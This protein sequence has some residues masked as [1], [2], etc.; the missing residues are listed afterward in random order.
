[1]LPTSLLSLCTLSPLVFLDAKPDNP[2]II[3]SATI[4]G[5]ILIQ[6]TDY[7][8]CRLANTCNNVGRFIPLKVA[9]SAWSGLLKFQWGEFIW[10]QYFLRHPYLWN[11]WLSPIAFAQKLVL[12][13]PQLGESFEFGIVESFPLWSKIDNASWALAFPRFDRKRCLSSPLRDIFGLL[14]N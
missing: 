12:Q 13:A 8:F 5:R 11:T 7:G 14:L 10:I 9:I 2:K 6:E 1:M 3:L 4:L